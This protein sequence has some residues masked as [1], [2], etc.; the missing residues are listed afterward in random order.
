MRKLE[1]LCCGSVAVFLG[2]TLPLAAQFP[3]LSRTA[4]AKQQAAD[5]GVKVRAEDYNRLMEI[6]VELAWLA[7]PAT[8]PC[9]LEAHVAGTSFLVKGHVPSRAVHE[10]ALQIARLHCP[11]SVT[12]GLKER[13]HAAAR[14]ARIP[15]QQLHRAALNSLQAAFPQSKYPF[16]VLCDADGKVKVSGLVASFEEKLAV[17]QALRR[18]HGCSCVINGAH[19]SSDVHELAPAAKAPRPASAPAGAATPAG[20]IQ[21]TQYLTPAVA[22]H[23]APPATTSKAPARPPAGLGNSYVSHGVVLLPDTAGVSTEKAVVLRRRMAQTCGIAADKIKLEV[24]SGNVLDIQLAVA[25]QAEGK[26][27]IQRIRQMPE[28]AGYRLQIHMKKAE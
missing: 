6:L 16:Q 26:R 1:W 23:T 22:E 8:F 20:N 25:G 28:V 17:S 24:K 21:R 10:R 12:D 7:D 14:P 4:P 2:V 15:A 3:G 11:M 5:N 13:S 9:L 19:V 27:L 18:L